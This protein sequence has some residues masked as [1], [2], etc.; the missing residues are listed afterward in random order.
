MTKFNP[1]NKDVLTYGECLSPAMEIT[2]KAD[3]DQYKRDY[4]AFTERALKENPNP[5]K[6]LTAE[7]IVNINL[8]YFAGYYSAETRERV[9]RLFEC[10]HPVFGA[11]ADNGAPTSEQAFQAGVN[12]AKKISV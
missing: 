3:A 7:K 5:D 10:A 4:I 12:A 9:E 2:D 11:I 6:N 1:E 8:A